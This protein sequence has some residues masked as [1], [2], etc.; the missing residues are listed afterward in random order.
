MDPSCKD[1]DKERRHSSHL[2]SLPVTAPCTEN[3]L[4]MEMRTMTYKKLISKRTSHEATS[5]LLGVASGIMI[6]EK[7]IGKDI[8]HK[9]IDD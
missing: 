3:L 9:E 5:G 6:N 2:H 4:I 1:S 7:S 8:F